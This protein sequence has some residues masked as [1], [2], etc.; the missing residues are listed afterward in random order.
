[1][2]Y[3]VHIPVDIPY[4]SFVV[5][6]DPSLEQ[7]DQTVTVIE[8]LE[9][10][11]AYRTAVGSPPWGESTAQPTNQARPIQPPQQAPQQQFVDHTQQYSCSRCGGPAER[12]DRAVKTRYGMKYPVNCLSCKNDKGYAFTT[13]WQD[14]D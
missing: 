8:A 7:I 10:A 6:Y 12:S 2:E 5:R 14:A 4:F 1:M 11:E 3:E 13:A 9:W